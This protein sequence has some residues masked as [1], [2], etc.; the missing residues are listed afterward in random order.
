MPDGK[1]N[2]LAGEVLPP[3][4]TRSY[5]NLY[6]I[7]APLEALT[8]PETLEFNFGLLFFSSFHSL[9]THRGQLKMGDMKH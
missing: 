9:H 7:I 2:E 4:K 8:K 1:H 3:V 5:D 6:F